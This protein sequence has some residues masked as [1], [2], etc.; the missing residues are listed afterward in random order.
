MVGFRIP[1]TERTIARKLMHIER[2]MAPLM[3][4]M[5]VFPNHLREGLLEKKNYSNIT[6]Q[7][8]SHFFF[9]STPFA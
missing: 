6:V 2:L 7:E 1:S 4:F 8:I 9:M 3:V 5:V